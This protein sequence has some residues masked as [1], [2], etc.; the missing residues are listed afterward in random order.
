MSEEKKESK[1]EQ[2]KESVTFASLANK[3]EAVNISEV[4]KK[5]LKLIRCRISCNNTNKRNLKGEIF[6]A[7]NAF[8][9]EI[10]KFI[11]FNVATHIPQILYNVIK[12]KFMQVFYE[13]KN[14][15]GFSIKRSRLMPE[16]NVEILP[17]ITK[18]ELEA[19]K[20]RQLADKTIES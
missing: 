18:Q 12:E 11:P 3:H 2:S 8:V 4:E 16:Y 9:N 19:I 13:E 1:K 14:P 10:K 5:A 17:A 7:R 15:K 6:T 20:Q